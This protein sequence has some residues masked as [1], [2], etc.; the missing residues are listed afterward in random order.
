MKKLQ[1]HRNEIHAKLNDNS[2]ETSGKFRKL[3]NR[4]GQFEST[5][6]K[7]FESVSTR[8]SQL[9][10]RLAKL[11][12]TATRPPRPEP[13][14]DNSN[15]ASS[16]HSDNLPAPDIPTRP[17]LTESFTESP[18]LYED[19]SVTLDSSATTSSAKTSVFVLSRM[20][21]F[22]TIEHAVPRTCLLPSTPNFLRSPPL[23]IQNCGIK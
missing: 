19:D 21:I 16:G 5:A 8:T 17:P 12:A 10:S 11:E 2:T 22:T 7:Q 18:Y 13:R 6:E 1:E 9:E 23:P 15:K 20:T 4:Y 3:D 14:P